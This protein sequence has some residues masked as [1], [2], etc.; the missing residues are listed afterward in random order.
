MCIVHHQF[1]VFREFKWFGNPNMFFEFGSNVPFNQ[2]CAGY[3][4]QSV[5]HLVWWNHKPKN[6]NIEFGTLI[7]IGVYI[8]L[9]SINIYRHTVQ[10]AI[11]YS[12]NSYF[13][14]C[15]HNI[16]DNNPRL[17]WMYSSIQQRFESIK[18][19]SSIMHIQWMA[20]GGWCNCQWTRLRKTLMCII[21]MQF[22]FPIYFLIRYIPIEPSSLHERTVIGNWKNW[23][24]FL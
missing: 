2:P 3:S 1:P 11:N 6:K 14:F 16:Y 10:K 17:R 21:W 23:V 20:D 12:R 5:F 4:V 19:A 15:I 24:R 8:T 22:L 7:N 13:P 9:K 18:Y